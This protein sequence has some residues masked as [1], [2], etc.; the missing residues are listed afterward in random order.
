MRNHAWNAVWEEIGDPVW[1]NCGYER[2][3][4]ESYDLMETH[5][6]S[7][8][9]DLMEGQFAAGAMAQ[10]DAANLEADVDVSAY[11]G[12]RRLARHCSWWWATGATAVLCEHPVRFDVSGDRVEIEYGDGWTVSG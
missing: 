5:L 11:D 3:A 7:W 8:E 1:T 10:F 6:T 12:T 9:E 4:R 2:S